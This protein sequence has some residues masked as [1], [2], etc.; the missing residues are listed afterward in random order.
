MS[1][2]LAD[3]TLTYPDGN[4]RPTALDVPAGHLAARTVPFVLTPATLLAPAAVLSLLGAA[5]AIRRITSVDP[6][7]SGAPA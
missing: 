3:I 5:L 4:T 1:L 6:L 7:T 2:H